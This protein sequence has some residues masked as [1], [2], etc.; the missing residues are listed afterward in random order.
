[1]IFRTTS[2]LDYLKQLQDLNATLATPEGNDEYLVFRD[3]RRGRN[4][5]KKEDLGNF[6][7]LL[8]WIDDRPDS[9]DSLSKSLGLRHKP[10]YVVAFFPKDLETQLAA[11]E[12]AKY[13]GNEGNIEE[14]IFRIESR[15][16][17]KFVPTLQSLKLKSN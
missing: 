12:K 8:R 6:S 5:G 13:S 15:P 2:G 3:L 10:A 7:N 14:T 9:V 4:I 11:L 1:M 16:G 17:G